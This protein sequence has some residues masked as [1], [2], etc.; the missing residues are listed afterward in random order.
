[1]LR[2]SLMSVRGVTAFGILGLAVMTAACS[3]LGTMGKGDV[4]V[5]MRLDDALAAPSYAVSAAPFEGTVMAG[6]VSPDAIASLIVNV[7]AVQFLP[8]T[9]DEGENGESEEDGWVS[10][11]LSEPIS[12]DLLALPAEGESPIVIA[13]G[14]VPVGQYGKVRLL[15]DGG[16]IQFLEEITIG[17][18]A[19]FEAGVDY[20]VDIPSGAQTG[21][22]TDVGFEVVETEGVVADVHLLFSPGATFLN[23]T[24]TGNGMV[25]LAPVIKAAPEP[26]T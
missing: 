15:T 16:T 26:G 4:A 25:K 20:A 7:T 2:G 6:P 3:D 17:N 13:S 19:T 5:T 9:A 23:L 14:E 22:K 10:L 1:M 8:L 11:E 18:A 21:L 24:V 12:L